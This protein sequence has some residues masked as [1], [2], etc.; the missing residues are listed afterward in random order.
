MFV[1]KAEQITGLPR[2]LTLA[3]R[4]LTLLETQVRRGL[5]QMQAMLDGLLPFAPIARTLDFSLIRIAPGKAVFQGKPGPQHFNTSRACVDDHTLSLALLAAAR[6]GT[7]R[8]PGSGGG[9]SGR[10]APQSFLP[11]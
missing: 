3:L 11:P 7:V 9:R 1:W 6:T 5:E 4:L 10:P 2:L 8:A